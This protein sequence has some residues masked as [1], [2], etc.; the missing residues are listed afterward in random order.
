MKSIGCIRKTMTIPAS[1][2]TKEI[3]DR[4]FSRERLARNPRRYNIGKTSGVRDGNQNHRR[5]QF[6]RRAV[7]QGIARTPARR[8]RR[9][10]VRRRN[11]GR[12]QAERKSSAGGKRG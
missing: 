11:T 9:N 4:E 10:A 3:P 7:A 8:Q 2:G 6:G 1:A 5:R 12:Q